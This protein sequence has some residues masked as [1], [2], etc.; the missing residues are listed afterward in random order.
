MDPKR[1]TVS[2]GAVDAVADQIVRR[3]SFGNDLGIVDDNVVNW[4]REEKRVAERSVIDVDVCEAAVG[5]VR[6]EH[7]A[8]LAEP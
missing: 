6:E 1:H 3:A 4:T 7:A 8:L 5:Q 2:V